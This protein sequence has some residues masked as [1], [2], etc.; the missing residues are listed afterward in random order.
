MTEYSIVYNEEGDDVRA[1]VAAL[2]ADVRR[3]APGLG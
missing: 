3:A 1:Q 2:I